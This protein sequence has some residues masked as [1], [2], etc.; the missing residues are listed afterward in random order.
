MAVE[1]A[2]LRDEVVEVLQ[3][4]F[5]V[6]GNRLNETAFENATRP[7]FQLPANASLPGG[8]G[9]VAEQVA[10]AVTD[11]KFVFGNTNLQEDAATGI[12]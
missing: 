9:E 6:A 5:E 3:D 12:F 7:G 4:V 2:K 11:A 10:E 8:N 1:T